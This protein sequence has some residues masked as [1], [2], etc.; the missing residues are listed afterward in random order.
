MA[1]TVRNP[2]SIIYMILTSTDP[3][4]FNSDILFSAFVDYLQQLRPCVGRR[5]VESCSRL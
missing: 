1:L 5:S 4:V 2:Y 3:F